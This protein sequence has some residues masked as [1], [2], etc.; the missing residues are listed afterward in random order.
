MLLMIT[1]D[2]VARSFATVVCDGSFLDEKRQRKVHRQRL[3]YGT[4]TAV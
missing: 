4:G 2:P 1:T 3:G